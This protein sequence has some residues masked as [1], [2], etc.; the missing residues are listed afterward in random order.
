MA[1]G[2]D[3]VVALG[4]ERAIAITAAAAELLQG[5]GLAVGAVGFCWGGTIALLANLRLGLPA[6]SYYGARNVQF[7]DEQLR[8]PMMFHF[9]ERDASIPP[10]AVQAHREQMPRAQVF[11]YP[12]GHAFNRDDPGSDAFEPESARL[13]HTRT[14]AFFEQALR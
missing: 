14:M 10:E 1:R 8:A 2:K 3:L 11:T 12:A 9:G 13:A 7:L 6:V 4:F 5:E